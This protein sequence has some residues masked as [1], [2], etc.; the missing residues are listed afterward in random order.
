MFLKV[1]EKNINQIHM[2]YEKAMGKLFR[3][4]N[5]KAN[6]RDLIRAFILVSKGEKEFEA[7]FAELAAVFSKKKENQSR[8]DTTARNAFKGLEKWQEESKMEL[9]RVKS[10]GK[11]INN[12]KK[13]GKIEYVKTKYEFVMLDELVKV[14]HSD[15]EN[16]DSAI[17]QVL[18]KI[19]TEYKPV[20]KTK[21]YHPLHNLKKAKNNIFTKLRRIFEYANEAGLKPMQKAEEILNEGLKI[22]EELNAEQEDKQNRAKFIKNFESQFEQDKSSKEKEKVTE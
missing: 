3:E 15:S 9:I 5:L 16:L 22:L 17:K 2:D 4:L 18:E 8:P 6:Q 21:K 10:V 12:I 7:S 1:E 19:K 14:L 20:E 13:G 11:R